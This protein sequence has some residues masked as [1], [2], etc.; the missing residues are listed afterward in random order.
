[1]HL[2][3]TICLVTLTFKCC[4][5][6]HLFTRKIINP[7]TGVFSCNLYVCNKWSDMRN[8]CLNLFFDTCFYK[9]L[10]YCSKLINGWNH[11]IRIDYSFR[12]AVCF[13]EYLWRGEDAR[14]QTFWTSLRKMFGQVRTW[15]GQLNNLESLAQRASGSWNNVLTLTDHVLQTTWKWSIDVPYESRTTRMS[16]LYHIFTCTFCLL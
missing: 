15:F 6:F 14:I 7:V 8:K 4:F 13:E 10:T 2:F 3:W 11:T 16:A 9:G 1:M 5:C 12:H